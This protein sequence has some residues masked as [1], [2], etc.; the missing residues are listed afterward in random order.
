MEELQPIQSRIYGIRNRQVMLDFDLADMYQIPTKRL[1]EQVRRNIERFPDDF[2][3]TLSGVEWKE[4]VAKCDQLPET[5]KHSPVAP[6][7]FTQEGVSMLS[8]ILRTP[9]AVQVN[10]RIMRAF[11]KM[12][13]YILTNTST[14]ELSRLQ[15]QIE[16]LRDRVERLN[17]DHKDYE[18]NFDDIYMVLAQLALPEKKNEPR[19]PIGFIK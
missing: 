13:E 3:F 15:G 11:V 16:F 7:A 6:F 9:V 5:I 1:K 18:R 17:R 10:I 2:M 4:L 19:K 8:G 12:R 14:E